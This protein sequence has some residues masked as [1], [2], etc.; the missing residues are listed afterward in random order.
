M[1]RERRTHRCQETAEEA[2][3]DPQAIHVGTR[4][5]FELDGVHVCL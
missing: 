1:R 5:W 2:V 3:V 4:E